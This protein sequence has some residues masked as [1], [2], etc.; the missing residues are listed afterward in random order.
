LK[1]STTLKMNLKDQSLLIK[2]HFYKKR[3][4]ALGHHII[5]HDQFYQFLG[6][7]LNNTQKEQTFQFFK[8]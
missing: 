6:E 3:D 5:W 2:K 7:E 8:S 4:M 1:Y